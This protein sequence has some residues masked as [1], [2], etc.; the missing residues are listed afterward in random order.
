MCQEFGDRIFLVQSYLGRGT[1][2]RRR[3]RSQVVDRA[4]PLAQLDRR[5]LHRHEGNTIVRQSKIAIYVSR[6][7]F[8]SDFRSALTLLPRSFIASTGSISK[9]TSLFQVVYF[10]SMFPYLVLTIFFIRGITLKGASA[11]L[12]HMYTPKV[13]I[14][15]D[16]GRGLIQYWRKGDAI[17]RTLDVTTS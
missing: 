16:R 9:S 12:A 15:P 10:T 13:T 7:K 14:D 2:D 6:S 8:H 11:G 3:P 17:R 4:L 5:L 1:V